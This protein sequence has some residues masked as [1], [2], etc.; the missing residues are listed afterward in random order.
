MATYV[1]I[2]QMSC[3]D[4]KRG[5]VLAAPKSS[6]SVVGGRSKINT[7]GGEVNIPDRVVVALV[8]DEIGEG[9]GIP[10]TNCRKLALPNG[11]TGGVFG[12]RDEVFA[13][14]TE[15]ET[16]D[17]ATVP[18]QSLD[19]GT[20]WLAHPFQVALCRSATHGRLFTIVDH[21][22]VKVPF[23]AAKGVSAERP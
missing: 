12:A 16:I 20:A 3:K 11:I 17:W 4:P 22:G 13:V 18:N 19:I 8:A 7:E 5:D 15:A 2:R 9:I 23:K 1:D 14:G 21:R 10:Q 6:S